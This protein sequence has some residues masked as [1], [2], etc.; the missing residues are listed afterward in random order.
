VIFGLLAALG[1]VGGFLS[2]LLGVGG[3]I[4]LVPLLLYV[5]QLLGFPSLGMRRVAGITI[6][7]VFAAAL[8]GFLV[9]RRRQ[10]T[11][12]QV[13]R[14]MGPGMVL[15]ATAGGVASKYVTLTVLEAAFAVLALVAAPLLFIPPPAD[16]IGQ[17]P[18]REF[19]RLLAL[20]TALWIGL[21]SGLVGVGGA[22]LTIPVMIYFLGVPTRAAIGSSL[23]V[24]L[25]S[26]LA[27]LAAK[28]STGQ[29][30][31]PW[32]AAL[33]VGALPGSWSGATMSRRL[34]ARDLRLLLAV[35]V[36]AAALRVL[37]GLLATL[38]LSSGGADGSP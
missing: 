31:L 21:L 6:V 7:Q 29:I 4:V 12:P 36:L 20:G 38:G 32:A 19:S 17:G 30:V 37:A 23:G 14:W 11:S 15:G 33:C 16:E 22:F 35:V 18:A 27:G 26:S 28:L 10:A 5:P 8:L 1:F 34:P 2:G 13:V 3:G 9:H 24:V 25:V